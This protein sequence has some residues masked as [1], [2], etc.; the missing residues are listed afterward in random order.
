MQS[1]VKV[2]K[3]FK[4]NPNP[5]VCPWNS[6]GNLLASYFT[7]TRHPFLDGCGILVPLWKTFHLHQRPGA[8]SCKLFDPDQRA[9][10]PS[11]ASASHASL[12]SYKRIPTNG[13]LEA[14]FPSMMRY[15]A[16]QNI[17][18]ALWQAPLILTSTLAIRSS[19]P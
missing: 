1:N 16:E 18:I 5:C 12:R 10:Q 11:T 15:D 19:L 2:S 3:Y 7:R 4:V 6:F 8:P 9:T 17:E 13:K 14:C